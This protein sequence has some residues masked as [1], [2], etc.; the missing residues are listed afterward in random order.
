MMTGEDSELRKEQSKTSQIDE[1]WEAL[2]RVAERQN[3]LIHNV[4]NT[5][6]YI[7]IYQ[8]SYYLIVTRACLVV[9]LRG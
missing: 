5:S 1:I 2:T 4:N 8:L 6:I 7:F 3:K 9:A